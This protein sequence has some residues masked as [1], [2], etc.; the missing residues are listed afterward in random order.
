MNEKKWRRCYSEKFTIL[1]TIFELI[2]WKFSLGAGAPFY[3]GLQKKKFSL[4][5]RGTLFAEN[6]M[7]CDAFCAK[8]TVK[9][10]PFFARFSWFFLEIDSWMQGQ[11]SGCSL[12]KW[13]WPCYRKVVI[14]VIKMNISHLSNIL[15]GFQ[16]KKGTQSQ[17]S[18]TSVRLFTGQVWRMR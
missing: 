14:N 13:I 8:S 3:V 7:G 5:L 16:G 17:P 2:S 18:T 4:P 10:F 11:L 12:F 1:L 15:A 6:F 9:N